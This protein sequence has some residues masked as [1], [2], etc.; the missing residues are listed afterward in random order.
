MSEIFLKQVDGVTRAYYKS[1]EVPI[2]GYPKDGADLALWAQMMNNEVLEAARLYY[3]D[4]WNW[5]SGTKEDKELYDIIEEEIQTR[6]WIRG[7]KNL[8]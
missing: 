8:I 7:I 2:P 5:I 1:R 6:D 4:K 3:F